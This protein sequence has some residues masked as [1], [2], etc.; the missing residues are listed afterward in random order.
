LII[1]LGG[2]N[3]IFTFRNPDGVLSSVNLAD[4]SGMI[5][6]RAVIRKY[7]EEEDVLVAMRKVADRSSQFLASMKRPLT[8]ID[9][10]KIA[11]ILQKGGKNN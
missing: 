6:F 5:N 7:L 9:I 10:L 3:E 2:K 11:L 8:A 1:K 4:H